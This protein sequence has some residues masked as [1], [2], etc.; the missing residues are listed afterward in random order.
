[1]NEIVQR[2]GEEYGMKLTVRNLLDV[3]SSGNALGFQKSS[4]VLLS[5]KKDHLYVLK[6]FHNDYFSS[7]PARIY[8]ESLS[9]FLEEVKAG[10]IPIVN[11]LFTCKGDQAMEVN[12]DYYVLYPYIVADQYRGSLG[13][14]A[15]TAQ[16][17]G[18]MNTVLSEMPSKKVEVVKKILKNS[19]RN[20]TLCSLL[21]QFQ[22]KIQSIDN[23]ELAST[24]RR[25]LP[26]LEK[27]IPLVENG[28]DSFP[29]QV[30]HKDI[31]PFNVLYIDG[32]VKAILDPDSVMY[33][34]RIRDIAYSA[35]CFST[36][37]PEGKITHPDYA[38]VNLYLGTY[39]FH[40]TLRKEEIDFLS[41]AMLRVWV[42][43]FLNFSLNADLTQYPLPGLNKKMKDLQLAVQHRDSL[44]SVVSSLQ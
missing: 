18:K 3:G 44:Q 24:M 20:E 23:L 33:L 11:Y 27:N 32:E 10:E 28:W 5:D 43:D 15:S 2:A 8:F 41:T 40:Q 21:N 22:L 13:E 9:Y 7:I 4:L 42:E 31:W 34:P 17:H 1:M 36:R 19:L 26:L 6:K 12:E 35:W 37:T 38:K 39:L 16:V 30:V 14:I 29:S 25:A